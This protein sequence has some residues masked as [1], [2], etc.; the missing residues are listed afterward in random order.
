MR[1]LLLLMGLATVGCLGFGAAFVLA[2][3]KA[4]PPT[5][6]TVSDSATTS[7]GDFTYD[8]QTIPYSSWASDMGNASGGKLVYVTTPFSFDCTQGSLTVSAKKVFD[9]LSPI[10]TVYTFTVGAGSDPVVPDGSVIV[11]V[12][13]HSGNDFNVNTSEW[14]SDGSQVKIGLDKGFSN[15]KVFSCTP[16][17]GTTTSTTTTATTETSESVTTITT[18]VPTTV[19]VPNT[20]VTL[21]AET[22]TNVT[23]ITVTTPA[24][25]VTLPGSTTVVT[26]SGSTTTVTLPGSTVTVPPSTVIKRIVGTFTP[27]RRIVRVPAHV[28]RADH[29]HRLVVRGLVRRILQR[30]VIVIVIHVHTTGTAPSSGVKGLQTGIGKG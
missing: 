25:T 13:I 9:S 19:T 20:T 23:T 27:P 12:A 11:G 30:K 29:V 8:G 16:V 14:V 6:S 21:P 26:V 2:G 18:T 5:T 3:S 28:I 7:P 1:R 17:G 15:A 4:G 24:S 10:P 22:V